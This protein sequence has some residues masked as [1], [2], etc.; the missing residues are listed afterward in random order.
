MS[1]KKAMKDYKLLPLIIDKKAEDKMDLEESE[2]QY[3]QEKRGD[4][5]IAN[6]LNR[7]R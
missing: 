5:I 7:F 4:I 1:K 6:N 3:L 2:R